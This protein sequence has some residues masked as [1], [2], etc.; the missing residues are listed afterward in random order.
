[1]TDHAPTDS[2]H[3]QPVPHTPAALPRWRLEAAIY[4]LL[5]GALLFD[6]LHL[7]DQLA[8][9]ERVVPGIGLD[10]G[11]VLIA[12]L[13]LLGFGTKSLQRRDVGTA[14]AFAMGATCGL[15]FFARTLG[16]ALVDPTAT[17]WLLGGDLAQHYSG[18]AVFRHAPWHWPPGLLPEV[19]YPVGTSIA[20]TDSLPLLAL[21]LKPLSPWLPEPFQYI[22][23]WLMLNCVLQGAT[24]ALLLTRVTRVPATILAGTALFVYAPLLIS[25]LGH[26]TLTTQWLLLASLWLYFRPTPP[27]KLAAEACPWWSIAGIAI[28][29]HPYLAAMTLAIQAAYWLK[30]WRVD[31]QRS[32]REVAVAAGVAL[33]IVVAL[34]WLS[35]AMILRSADSS[36]GVAYG[37]YSFNLLGF[38]NPIGH[39]RFLPNLPYL[40]DQY[41]GF[42][43]LGI[44]VLALAAWLLVDGVLRL[45]RLPRL[46][47][48]WRPLALVAL[49]LCVFAA[50]SVVAIGSWVLVDLPLDV[51]LLGAFRASGRFV[52]V[53]YYTLM[54]LIVCTAARRYR[55]AV[56]GGLL[57]LTL[58]V[59]LADLSAV[60]LH[61][62]TTRLKANAEVPGTRLTDPRWADLA[63]GRRHLTMLPPVACGKSAGSYLPFQLFAAEHELTLNTGYVARWNLKATQQYCTDLAE[64]AGAGAWSAQDI[65]VIG[66]AERWKAFLEQAPSLSCEKLDGY[67][68][69]VVADRGGATPPPSPS[70]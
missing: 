18:W 32:L 70:R 27:A 41:E 24:A 64:R 62:A 46:E 2:L 67:D 13:A 3:P 25:R 42:A 69:C 43:Y 5:C 20:Y 54:L 1:M 44:G 30:R 8:A 57:G 10:R 12:A 19:W 50:S 53:A 61:Y 66:P 48:S 21:L 56:A 55:P 34:F 28:L 15:L 52:W 4:V 45:R 36:G 37:Y 11:I 35:G 39:S 6:A 40:K 47:P 22:G 63:R 29:V 58:I 68:V 17:G 38:F 65:Y 59:Q 7:L 31:R 9:Q 51:P 23:L 49:A 33:A 60:H 14:L 26:D 16:S